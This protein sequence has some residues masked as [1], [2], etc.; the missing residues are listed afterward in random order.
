MIPVFLQDVIE[1]DYWAALL[2]ADATGDYT[3]IQAKLD[4]LTATDRLM[5]PF[6]GESG[7]K[8]YKP[9]VQTTVP[10][11]L[12]AI[13]EAIMQNKPPEITVSFSE[14]DETRAR[15]GIGAY[16]SQQDVLYG[17]TSERYPHWGD[18]LLG[19]GF[20]AACMSRPTEAVLTMAPRYLAM[21]IPETEVQE[22]PGT[23]SNEFHETNKVVFGEMPF[24]HRYRQFCTASGVADLS[25]A[26][27]TRA[28][29]DNI[30]TQL[31]ALPIGKSEKIELN[32]QI[33]TKS[34]TEFLADTPTPRK[35]SRFLTNVALPDTN[36]SQEQIVLKFV[37]E[38]NYIQKLLNG[39]RVE[40]IQ[41]NVK[42]VPNLLRDN[43]CEVDA[44]YRVVGQKK[45]LLLEAK[46]KSTIAR[47]QLYG[48]YET[49][50]SRLPIDWDLEIV[51]A[52][53]TNPTDEQRESGISTCIDL[54]EVG[55]SGQ[56]PDTFTERL[57]QVAPKRH[58]RWLIRQN[59]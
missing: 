27:Q 2:L 55:L 33:L 51:A 23:I 11:I 8:Y 56:L 52:M 16:G 19:M 29:L 47:A 41:S 44:L 28:D 3:D 4:A 14:I 43:K 35:I 58:F 36:V 1:P 46:G 15:L 39:H 50:R 10:K 48:V 17:F 37:T 21:G 31:S 9:F 24:A 12:P 22:L 49:F 18:T 32:R 40:H 59:L 34:I 57:L 53:V 25:H 7:I 30:L 54:I 42:M 26:S 5:Q 45:I 13:R 38:G 6:A 20:R